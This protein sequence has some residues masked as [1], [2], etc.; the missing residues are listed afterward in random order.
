[1]LVKLFLKE[2]HSDKMFD[3]ISRT[4]N[5]EDWMSFTSSWSFLEIARALKKSGKPK[6]IIEL[7]LRE[8]RSH[9]IY[10]QTITRKIFANAERIVAENNVYASDAIHAATFQDLERSKKLE[11]FLTDDRHFS[12]LKKIVNIKTIDAL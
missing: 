2:Q 5:E 3:I 6:E 4:D 7:D 8:L 9:R 11:G 12:R 1:M 10:Y